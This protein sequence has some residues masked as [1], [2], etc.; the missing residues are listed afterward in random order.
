[1]LRRFLS[2]CVCAQAQEG[3]REGEEDN[4]E[5]PAWVESLSPEEQQKI[6]HQGKIPWARAVR[7]YPDKIT[8]FL[9][10]REIGKTITKHQLKQGCEA[11]QGIGVTV[12][13]KNQDVGVLWSK[14]R[15]TGDD[16]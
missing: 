2:C 13:L 7:E 16:S 9:L 14:L 4:T 12:C 6:Q 8:E 15:P 5:V 3:L 11:L 10:S 1:L